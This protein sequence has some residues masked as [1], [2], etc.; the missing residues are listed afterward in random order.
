[1]MCVELE[2]CSCGSHLHFR[3]AQERTSATVEVE[4][5]ERLAGCSICGGH[6]PFHPGTVKVA[7][8]IFAVYMENIVFTEHLLRLAM[9]SSS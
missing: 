6:S 5:E 7:K 4:A 3:L 1:M 8:A 2:M 9:R